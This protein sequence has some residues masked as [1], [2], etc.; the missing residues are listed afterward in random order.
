[1]MILSGLTFYASVVDVSPTAT[2]FE[3]N[4]GDGTW[5]ACAMPGGTVTQGPSVLEMNNGA[6][7]EKYGT[8]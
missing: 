1:M 6:G 3:V 5:T 2:V 8:L 7:D 4:C